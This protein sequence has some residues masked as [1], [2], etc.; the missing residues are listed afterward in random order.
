MYMRRK[1]AGITIV[2]AGLALAACGA[3]GDGASAAS[4]ATGTSSRES[5]MKLT[6]TNVKAQTPGD[7]NK[8]PLDYGE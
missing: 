2:L 4:K 1:L 6:D 3:P 8:K 7:D 5:L